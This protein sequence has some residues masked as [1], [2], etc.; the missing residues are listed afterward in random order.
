M[1]CKRTKVSA[2]IASEEAQG[3]RPKILDFPDVPN[4]LLP[5][6]VKGSAVNGRKSP[7]V[8]LEDLGDGYRAVFLLI[9]FE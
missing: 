6:I 5:S 7:H 9:I 4:L 8:W 3:S 1:G 2:G